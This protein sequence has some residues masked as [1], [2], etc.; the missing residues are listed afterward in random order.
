MEERTL[1]PDVGYFPKRQIGLLI[2]L[3]AIDGRVTVDEQ[4]REGR[5]AL[6]HRSRQLVD[7]VSR[8]LLRFGSRR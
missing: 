1:P 8:L 6:R 5:I 2:D 3:W 4:A 7:D